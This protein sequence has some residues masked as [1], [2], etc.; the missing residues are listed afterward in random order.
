MSDEW[1]EVTR[2][3]LRDGDLVRA[4]LADEGVWRNGRLVGRLPYTESP[5][6]ERKV[7]KPSPEAMR[8][9]VA[10]LAHEYPKGGWGWNL[11]RQ[12]Q[13]ARIIDEV[14]RGES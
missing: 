14:Y 6:Y 4:T 9:A 3:E 1:E 8:A 2:E 10:V 5:R 7:V 12:T 11:G 13:I